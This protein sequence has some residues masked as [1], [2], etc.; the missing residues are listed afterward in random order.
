V[1]ASILPLLRARV[2]RSG[3]MFLASSPELPNLT[4][5][6]LTE[7]EAARDLRRRILSL[8]NKP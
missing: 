4:G 1:N 5:K 6:G 2:R 3:E 7:E 8:I